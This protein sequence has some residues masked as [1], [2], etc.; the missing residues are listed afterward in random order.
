M[1]LILNIIFL[2][3]SFY[4][5]TKAADYF[6]DEAANVGLKFGMSKLTIGLTIVAIGTSLPELITSLSAFL[7]SENASQFIIGTTLGSNITNILLAFGLFL[8][9][10][11]NFETKKKET[12]NVLFLLFTTIILSLFIILGYVNYTVLLLLTFYVFYIIFLSKF[13][14]AEVINEEKELVDSKKHGIGTSIIILIFSFIGLFLGAKLVIFS[15][16]NLGEILAIP[17]AY[18]TLSTISVATSLPE[19]AVTV[20]AARKKEH[21]IA[22]GNIL[23]TNIMNVCLII[24]LSGFA[25]YYAINTSLY[26]VSIIFFLLAT[27]IFSWMVLRKKFYGKIGYLFLFMYVLYLGSLISHMV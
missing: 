5:I 16:E 19:I 27:F 21:L 18:L 20:A 2:I 8:I 7:F 23:G 9:F 26:I 10:S 17:A 6:V 1:D 11:G 3:I 13:H 12:Y 22:I 15:I 4:I 14:K 25:G 24:G